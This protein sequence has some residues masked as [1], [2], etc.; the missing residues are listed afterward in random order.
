MNTK[1]R[2]ILTTAVLAGFLLAGL[3][4]LEGCKKKEAPAPPTPK[5][6]AAPA[7]VAKP[8]EANKPAAVVKAKEAAVAAIE[9][10]TCPV[11]PSPIDKNV[12]TEY[13]GKKVYFCCTNCKKAF[14]LDPEKY[15]SKLPQFA[16]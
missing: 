4:M 5:P 15:V 13:K 16:K 2:T 11:L 14:E 9:Q 10:T 1:N 8:A 7:K 3:F 6:A 12:F